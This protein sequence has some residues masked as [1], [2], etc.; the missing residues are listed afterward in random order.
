MERARVQQLAE[1]DDIINDILEGIWL[2]YDKDNS[3]YLDKQETHRFVKCVLSNMGEVEVSND[4]FERFFREFDTDRNG[5]I[6]KNEMR[7]F[8]R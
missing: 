4:S 1:E 2:T 8:I 6:T 5:I 3:G 7:N